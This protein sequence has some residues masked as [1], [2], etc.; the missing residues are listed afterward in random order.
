MTTVALP[1]L[2]AVFARFAS[3]P[4]FAWSERV[5]ARVTVPA[6][7]QRVAA[8]L[9]G[10]PGL[11]AALLFAF[12]FLELFAALMFPWDVYF[13]FV[14][15][16][17][18]GLTPQPLS[19]WLTDWLKGKVVGAFF[20]AALTLGLFGLAKRLR[21]WWLVLGGVAAL[22]LVGSAAID[23]YRSQL[24]VTQR[25]LE[26]GSLRS[27]LE[28]QLRAG[29]VE[30]SDIVVDETSG[31]SV[32][33]QAYFAGR[34]P[35]RRIVLNDSLLKALDASQVAAAVAHEMGH[36][37]ERRWP[38]FVASGVG[39]IVFLALVEWLFRWS[40]RRKWAGITSRGDVR[41]LP[42]VVLG[43]DL[44]MLA[45]SPLA[46]AHSR[47]RELDADRYAVALTGD[48]QAFRAMLWV[49]GKTNQ[50]HP[51]PPRWYV[52]KGLSHPPLAERLA[53]VDRL[54]SETEA[55]R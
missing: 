41:V 9:W 21:W 38:N 54:A 39:L 46:G 31:R 45:A 36:V 43:F 44:A 12:A 51:S 20:V 10:G 23:P 33:L 29:G 19:G 26:A 49:A 18:F 24:Y 13:G 16:R 35:T 25:P 7:L 3:A 53:H 42:L 2:L 28:A 14:R 15:E 47:Q 34:G 27:K 37:H 5:A 11:G 52:L 22:A 1:V 50:M 40:V 4:L 17:E 30:F 55:R 8:L 32:R 6:A 48:A